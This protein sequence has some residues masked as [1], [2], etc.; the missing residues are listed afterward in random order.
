MF[1]IRKLEDTVGSFR[2]SITFLSFL[3]G[4]SKSMTIIVSDHLRSCNAKGNDYPLGLPFSFMEGCIRY[5]CECHIDGSWECPAD[6]ADD[7]CEFDWN[8]EPTPNRHR[9]TDVNTRSECFSDKQKKLYR[10]F[11]YLL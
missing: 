11:Q 9:T 4:P 1:K 5:N 3:V 10:F 6:K 8:K 7:T 2:K